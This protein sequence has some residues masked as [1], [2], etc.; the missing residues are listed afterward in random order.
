MKKLRLITIVTVAFELLQACHS[1]SN[2]ENTKLADSLNTVKDTTATVGV[3]KTDEAFAVEAARGSMGEIV[4]G[5][6]AQQKGQDKRVKNFGTMMINDHAKINKEMKAL[7]AS[8]KITLPTAPGNDEQI[9]IDNLS[10]KTGKDFDKAFIKD[11]IEDHKNDI[12][13]FENAS[14]KCADPDIK[15]FAAKLLPIFH[16]HLDAINTING[17]LK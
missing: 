15:A 14:S 2:K 7:A 11:M 3:E 1:P 8:K 9:V 12:K 5:K 4:L 10:K 13:A 6:L 17:S 16:N